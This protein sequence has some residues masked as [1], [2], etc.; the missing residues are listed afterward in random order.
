MS[1]FRITPDDVGRKFVCDMGHRYQIAGVADGDFLIKSD[2]YPN[3]G[4][5][6]YR[7]VGHELLIRGEN[8]YFNIGFYFSNW[9]EEPATDQPRPKDL[10][11]EFAMVALQGLVSDPSSGYQYV[12]P[13]S[14][15]DGVAKRAYELA[16]AMMR[17]RGK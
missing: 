7:L 4:A 14:Y 10:R 1:T 8:G 2:E 3:R 9:I 12:S 17:A 15:E 13:Q 16:D 11:D 5:S 6:R